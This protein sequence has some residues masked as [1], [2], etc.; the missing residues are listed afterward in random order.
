MFHCLLLNQAK[1]G[2]GILANQVDHKL[3]DKIDRGYPNWST[4]FIL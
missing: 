4:L 1:T 3:S 2:N